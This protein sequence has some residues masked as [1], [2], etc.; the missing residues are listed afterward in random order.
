MACKWQFGSRARDY[1]YAGCAYAAYLAGRGNH[2][3]CPHCDQ[4][5]LPDQPWDRAH[6]GTPRCFGGKSV[7][8]GHRRCNRLDNNK[9]VTPAFHKANRVRA[10][11][12]LGT[13]GRGLGRHPM[14]CGRASGLRKSMG[15]RV[16]ARI[17]VADA[18]A[19]LMAKR[20]PFLQGESEP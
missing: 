8:V 18:H 17:S 3:I 4:P 11:L 7:A 2:P 9:V 16:M 20:Y 6:V 10:K 13:K 15:G 14:P 1:L 5:V 19:A 12:V